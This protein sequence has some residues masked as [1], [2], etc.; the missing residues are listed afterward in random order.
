[1]VRGTGW[2]TTTATSVLLTALLFASPLEALAVEGAGSNGVGQPAVAPGRIDLTPNQLFSGRTLTRAEALAA[3]GPAAAVAFARA[4]GKSISLDAAVAIARGVGWTADRGMTGP[5]GELSLL[6]TLGI[7]ARL[8]SGID[9]AKIAREVQ[10]GRPVI[11]RTG[12][13]DAAHYF[14][15]ER[16][17]GAGRFDF[18][19]SALV[20]RAA[21]GRR[22][23]G[24][25]EIGQLGVGTPTH[26]IFMAD[27]ASAVSSALSVASTPINAGGRSRVVDAGG[28]G[29]RLRAEPGPNGRIVGL[30]ADGARLTDLGTSV[31]AS[32]RT[33]RR[34]SI[35]SGTTAWIDAGL[36]RAAQ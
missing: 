29:A 12:G 1:M 34:V 17:D 25:D 9:R 3:C 30:V 2:R 10:A 31:V 26:A 21:A 16:A 22:W 5:W 27:S 19:Q 15:A 33:W 18:G 11:I 36:L 35:A 14:V 7:P 4:M 24:I 23:F 32:G 13:S 6:Q 8:E 20:L 28:L